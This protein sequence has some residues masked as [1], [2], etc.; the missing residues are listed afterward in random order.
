MAGQL[1][2]STVVYLFERKKKPVLQGTEEF[3]CRGDRGGQIAI[4]STVQ[5][6]PVASLSGWGGVALSAKTRSHREHG[7]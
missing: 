6:Y 2:S 4:Y 1:G 5:A 3:S 7:F